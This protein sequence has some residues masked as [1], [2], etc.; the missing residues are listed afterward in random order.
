MSNEKDKDGLGDLLSDELGEWDDMFDSLHEGS[1]E[2][3][4]ASEAA[5]ASSSDPG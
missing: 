5:P 3:A 4:P 1:T 2:D